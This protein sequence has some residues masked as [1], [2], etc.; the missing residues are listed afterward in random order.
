M[1]FVA[2]C[3]PKTFYSGNKDLEI[4]NC[5]LRSELEDSLS[6]SQNAFRIRL[7]IEEVTIARILNPFIKLN[8]A[9]ATPC[10]DN[11]VGL[12]LDIVNFEFKYNKSILGMPAEEPIDLNKIRFTMI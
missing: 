3:K 7:R 2:Y 4:A 10:E 11:F 5:L 12:K 9:Y 1:V 8:A 6:I